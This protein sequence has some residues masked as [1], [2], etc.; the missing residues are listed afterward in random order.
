[1]TPR[2]GTGRFQWNTGG[3]FGSQIGATAYLGLLGGVLAFQA[4]RAGLLLL[5]CGLLPNLL[6][7]LLWLR[8]DRLAP[9]PA[10]QGLLAIVLVCTAIALGGLVWGGP[11]LGLDPRFSAEIRQASWILLLF[12]G[13][14]VL[15]H[16]QEK[17]PPPGA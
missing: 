1:V 14:M 9:Y 2:K 13:L 11:V 8:R 3:W 7:T 16:L 12:P 10:L 15:F 17:S 4:P 5:F 6:G